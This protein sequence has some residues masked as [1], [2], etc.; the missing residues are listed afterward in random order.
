M[1]HRLSVQTKLV[2]IVTVILIVGGT[3]AMYFIEQDK[4]L[5]GYD[6]GEQILISAFQSV[7]TRTAGFN[8]V[9]IG[10]LS[11]SV[12]FGFMLLMFIGASSG[13]TGGGIKTNTFAILFLKSIQVARGSSRFQIYKRSISNEIVDRA[14]VVF[15]F[16]SALVA[17]MTIVILIIEPFTLEQIMF[18]VISAFGTVGLST[19]I[20]PKLSWWGKFLIIITMYIGR[21]GPL[22]VAFNYK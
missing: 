19:G 8:S 18:E 10:A 22:T 11:S 5:K 6:F 13:S 17:L 2:L 9:D 12:L 7:T 20:T 15:F 1:K 4:I 16:S 3:V 14:M 21:V